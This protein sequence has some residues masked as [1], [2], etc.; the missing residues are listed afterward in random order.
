MIVAVSP[1]RRNQEEHWTYDGRWQEGAIRSRQEA[2][3]KSGL[4]RGDVHNIASS[5]FLGLPRR[6]ANGR[7]VE[8]MAEFLRSTPAQVVIWVA[9]LLMVAA[10]GVYFALLVRNRGGQSG[11]PS[12]DMLADF[13]DLHDRGGLSETEFKKIKSV[14]GEKLQ[15]ELGSK[16][17]ESNG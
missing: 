9:V 14:L 6:Q 16:D 7:E 15:D 11:A 8:A 4:G 13:R 2:R 1:W 5:E 12:S 3:G 17:A 10:F